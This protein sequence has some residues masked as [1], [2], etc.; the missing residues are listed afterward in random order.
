MGTPVG[1]VSLPPRQNINAKAQK[2]ALDMQLELATP[3][4]LPQMQLYQN[5]RGAVPEGPAGE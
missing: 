1:T 5:N 2:R 4:Q 3:P